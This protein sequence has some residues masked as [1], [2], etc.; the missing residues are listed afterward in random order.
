MINEILETGNGYYEIN[1]LDNEQDDCSMR[2][3]REISA[4]QYIQS[5][6]GK[7]KNLC[8]NSSTTTKIPPYP[9]DPIQIETS[10]DVSQTDGDKD[11]FLS[12][13][14]FPIARNQ[15]FMRLLCCWYC[16]IWCLQEI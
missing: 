5:V 13:V 8:I 1:Q 4:M 11:V 9:S 7:N 14:V 2:Q 12:N 10:T 16:G 15:Y 6:T 3:Y